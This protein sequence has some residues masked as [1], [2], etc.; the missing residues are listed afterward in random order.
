MQLNSCISFHACLLL[1]NIY[2][3]DFSSGFLRFCWVSSYLH[4]DFWLKLA[5]VLSRFIVT[6]IVFC[7]KEQDKEIN[8]AQKY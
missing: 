3:F 2:I 5:V 1:L 7:Q 8:P 6:Y 4:L